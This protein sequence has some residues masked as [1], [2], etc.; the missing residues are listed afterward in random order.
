MWD[1][2]TL[3][4]I[5]QY[6]FEIQL[7]FAGLVEKQPRRAVFKIQHQSNDPNSPETVHETAIFRHMM[8]KG[9]LGPMGE[10]DKYRPSERRRL[11]G[12]SEGQGM[13]NYPV[14][15]L[16]PERTEGIFVIQVR[17]GLNDCAVPGLKIDREA[18]EVSLD[19]RLLY[20]RFFGERRLVDSYDGSVSHR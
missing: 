2:T 17:A 3:D 5:D 13:P 7:R 18:R 8:E 20:S 15:I 11:F 6:D 14:S 16:E 12:E 1:R 10:A 19:W 9:G 4:N